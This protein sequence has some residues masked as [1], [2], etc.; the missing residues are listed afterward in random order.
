MC[1][2]TSVLQSG[3]TQ[4]Q[5]HLGEGCMVPS[6]SAMI[7]S[8]RSSNVIGQRRKLSVDE[9]L[10]LIDALNRQQRRGDSIQ[11]V[12]IADRF[13]FL[14]DFFRHYTEAGSY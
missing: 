7:L 13:D 12:G 8:I 10:Q 14:A 1:E 5:L 2:T 11:I 3:Q 6:S 4:H 9:I